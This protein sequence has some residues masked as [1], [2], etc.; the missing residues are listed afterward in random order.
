LHLYNTRRPHSRLEGRTPDEF[1]F[2]S[3]PNTGKA[4]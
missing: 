1:Y 3:L 2:A 4:A